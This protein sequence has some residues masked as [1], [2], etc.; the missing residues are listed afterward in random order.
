MVFPAAAISPAPTA[1]AAIIA[2]PALA[3]SVS[4]G[5][6]K[7]G[8]LNDQSG[9]YAD[10]GGLGSVEAAIAMSWWDILGDAGQA[11]SLEHFGAS[12]PYEVL[13]EKFGITPEATVAA[14]KK[15]LKIVEGQ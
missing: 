14:A 4:D 10:F 9:V 11:V 5:K 8:I 3:Q 15:S 12:A 2:T 13:Y 6:V 7:I 1:A